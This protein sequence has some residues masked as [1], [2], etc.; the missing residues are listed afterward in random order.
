[1]KI[2][3][4]IKIF[5]LL[6]INS[7]FAASLGGRV[8]IDGRDPYFKFNGQLIV[9]TDTSNTFGSVAMSS[10]GNFT[11]PN[12]V[13]DNK[14]HG[15][16]ITIKQ[17]PD[18]NSF[19]CSIS[20]NQ[21]TGMV[22]IKDKTDL[23]IVC[24][25]QYYANISLTGLKA[26]DSLTA[27]DLQN[28]T[29]TFTTNS[30]R[31]FSNWFYN[32]YVNYYLN[33]IKYNFTYAETNYRRC[34]S[35]NTGVTNNYFNISVNCFDSSFSSIT[36]AAVP[37]AR[38]G[39]VGWTD[40]DGNYYLFGGAN[41]Y[42]QQDLWM[43]IGSGSGSW[44]NLTPSTITQPWPSRRFNS[45]AWTD[46][47]GNMYLFGGSDGT[48]LLN[49]LWKLTIS[50]NTATW[51]QITS[52]STLPSGRDDS[53][54]WA[55]SS[56]NSYLFGGYRSGRLND[57]WK[58]TVSNNT[59]TWVQITS[60]STLPSARYGSS[61]WKDSS[62]NYYLFGGFDGSYKQD[63]WKLT[64]SDNTATWV[65]ITSTS[66]LPSGRRSSVAWTD[67]SSNIYLFGGYN[68]SFIQDLWKISVSSYNTAIWVNLTPNTIPTSWPSARYDSIAWKDSSGNMYLFGGYNGSSLQDLW[69]I[70]V[71]DNSPTW[72]KIDP[73][74][75]SARTGSVGWTDSS[76]NKYLF[77]GSGINSSYYQDLWKLIFSSDN[78]GTWVN[79]TP[80]TISPTSWP[81]ARYNSIVWTDSSGNKYLFGGIGYFFY[82][83]LW[84][85]TVSGNIATWV[86]LTPNTI[87]PTSW[88]SARFSSSTWT[89]NSGNKYLLG[90]VGINTSYYQDLWKLTVSGN[91]ATWVNLTPNTISPTSWPSARSGSVVWTDNSGNKYLFGGENTNYLN[92]LFMI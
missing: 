8:I 9:I 52:T 18:N 14:P 40:K 19:I 41:S 61:V 89:D 21:V 42:Y 1:M 32:N 35:Q 22:Y 17:G 55:D 33:S 85:L 57:L 76:G 24:R 60:T 81:S 34:V 29:L 51:V 2:S 91:I 23:T 68:G 20:D 36:V 72:T 67:S 77:G 80:N 64:V 73:A 38:S 45:V 53:V 88:P 71:S 4:Y 11:L 49:D 13:T 37:S 27:T 87:S 83:D 66:T 31:A 47:S 78:T 70:S 75:P 58:L 59:A 12:T 90:G 43:H 15:Y 69:K 50:D 10:T 28:E 7:I 74:Q 79:L 3:N 26:Q 48:S 92:D 16:S 56:G 63:L 46:S 62:G 44:V 84:K 6:L 86:N 30:T 39:S 25:G 82:Q 5:L 54:A 65:Q